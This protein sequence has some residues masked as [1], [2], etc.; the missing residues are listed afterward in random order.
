MYPIERYQ[1][2]KMLDA[3]EMEKH[4]HRWL[5]GKSK[6][7]DAE[8]NTDAAASWFRQMVML[9]RAKGKMA[10]L[11]RS[12]SSQENEMGAQIAACDADAG[13]A[14]DEGKKAPHQRMSVADVGADMLRRSSQASWDERRSSQM[15]GNRR[16]AA[17]RPNEVT[18]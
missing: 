10:G 8:N 3:N 2:P 16:S 1:A 5:H 12:R 7:M 9:E 11:C 14:G 18:V 15:A 17:P 6:Y 4:A 13:G